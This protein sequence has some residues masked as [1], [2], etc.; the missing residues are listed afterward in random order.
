MTSVE[1]TATGA[2]VARLV[3]RVFRGWVK[4]VGFRLLC[5]EVF[6]WGRRRMLKLVFKP[7]WVYWK[8]LKAAKGVAESEGGLK[9]LGRMVWRWQAFAK[10]MKA[11]KIR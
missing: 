9:L 11:G 4:V 6:E 8:L 7:L 1:E 2:S 5:R 3:Q 10:H